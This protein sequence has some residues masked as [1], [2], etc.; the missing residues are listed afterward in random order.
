MH[1]TGH[2]GVAN[3]AALR[4][5][6]IDAATPDP[7]A[8]TIDRDA[9]GKPTG[10]LKESAMDAVTD[11]IPPPTPSSCAPASAQHRGPCI[12]KA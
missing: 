11:L 7:K 6:K 1:T 12:A 5:A 9:Q 10:V 8:G 4:L 3:S 2:Y